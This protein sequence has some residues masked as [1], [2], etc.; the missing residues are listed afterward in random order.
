[1]PLK[2][3]ISVK[4]KKNQFLKAVLPYLQIIFLFG[5]LV[6]FCGFDAYCFCCSHRYSYQK[7]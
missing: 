3:I 7:V 6:P 4:E 5:H 2:K 1:M